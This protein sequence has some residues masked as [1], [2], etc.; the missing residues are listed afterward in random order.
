M[1]LKTA[2]Y[3]QGNPK[4]MEHFMEGAVRGMGFILIKDG[5]QFVPGRDQDINPTLYTR[6]YQLRLDG[7]PQALKCRFVYD[8]RKNTSSC[9]FR[10]SVGECMN[11]IAHMVVAEEVNIEEIDW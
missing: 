6:V 11:A 7:R 3:V 8:L 4:P 1:M 10:P 5:T 2:T 9:E